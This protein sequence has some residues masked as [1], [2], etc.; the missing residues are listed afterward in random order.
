MTTTLA[1]GNAVEM[2]ADL[3][4]EELPNQLYVET[5]KLPENTTVPTNLGMSNVR[6]FTNDGLREVLEKHGLVDLFFDD[7]GM[8]KTDDA[9]C[10]IYIDQDFRDRVATAFQ[11]HADFDFTAFNEMD[12]ETFP[13]NFIHWLQYWVKET[14]NDLEGAAFI[15]IV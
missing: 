13:V 14:D 4:D 15:A 6:A 1:I 8:L 5:I 12:E 3:L 2:P 10:G 9:A 7:E 11:P